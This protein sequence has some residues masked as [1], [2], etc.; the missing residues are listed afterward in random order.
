MVR[1][2]YA[3]QVSV[4][5]FD[6]PEVLAAIRDV[7]PERD[8][9]AHVER[10]VWEFA[11]LAMF[12]ADVGV[13]DDEST[14]LAVGAGDERVVFWLAERVGKVIATDTYGEGAFAGREADRAMLLDPASRSPY[15]SFREDRLEVR[16]MDARALDLPDGSVDAAYSLSSFEHFGG[17]E[18]IARAAAELGRVL[19]PGGHAMVVTEGF[20]RLHPL[21]TAKVDNAIRALTLGRKRRAATPQRRANLGEVLTEQEL[22]ELVVA[23][24]GLELLQPLKMGVSARTWANLTSTEGV[25]GR[26]SPRSGAFHPHLLLQA[27]RSVYTSVALPLRKPPA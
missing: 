6:D 13:L 19:K 20:V 15:P 2:H 25:E 26:L 17:P 1:R 27:D 7:V 23:P 16:S 4:E 14:V 24:S 8:P 12:F 21:N 10:K 22:H 3:K 9:R 5:D 18:D 11:M